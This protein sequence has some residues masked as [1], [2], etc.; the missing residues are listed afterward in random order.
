MYGYATDETQNFAKGLGNGA[1]AYPRLRI[2]ANTTRIF[3]G[4]GL[5]ENRKS[6]LKEK[7]S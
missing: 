5:T 2:C 4:S 1:R 7:L 3:S 6:P